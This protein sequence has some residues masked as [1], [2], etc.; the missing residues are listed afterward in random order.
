MLTR[1]SVPC[2]LVTKA[3]PLPPTPWG[4][5]PTQG[6]GRIIGEACHFI[7]FLTFLVGAPP[8]SVH[9]QALP[10]DGRYREDNVVMVFTFADGS[11]GTVNYLANG[12]KAFPKER[13]VVF[14]GGRVAALDDF[15]TLEMVRSA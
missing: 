10:D 5:S 9:A 1:S 13:V 8:I 6:G 2:R 11:L 7:D 14:A 15:R 12:D 3:A 4:P